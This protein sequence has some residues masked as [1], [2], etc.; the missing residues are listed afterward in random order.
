MGRDKAL[1][2]H[3]SGGTLLEKQAG[4]L[5][6]LGGPVFLLSGNGRRYPALGY[7]E[8]PDVQ[9]EAGPVGGILAAL[10]DAGDEEALILA[11]DLPFLSEDSLRLILDRKARADVTLASVDGEAQPVAGLWRS[12]AI[13]ALEEALKSGNRK[14]HDVLFELELCLIDLPEKE[15]ENWNEPGD[16]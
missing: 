3:P 10:R 12:S 14:L 8:I 7:P 6:S 16:L 2:P 11:V 1:L 15:L 9:R 4:L 13:P 5:E